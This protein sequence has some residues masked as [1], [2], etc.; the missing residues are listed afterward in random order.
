[1]IPSY[2]ADTTE[3]EVSELV[4]DMNSL[5]A[6]AE[7][8]LERLEVLPDTSL[9]DIYTSAQGADFTA[10]LLRAGVASEIQRRVG[11]AEAERQFGI[12]AMQTGRKPKTLKV[13]A[14]I[15][16]TF[17]RGRPRPQGTN[18]PRDFYS[19]ALADA[20]PLDAIAYA[21]ERKFA[22]SYTRDDFRMEIKRRN[23]KLTPD[24]ES[25]DPDAWYIPNIPIS[26]Q[27]K[28]AMMA[29]CKTYNARRRR[30]GN[31]K[32]VRPGEVITRALLVLAS[33]E[34][35]ADFVGTGEMPGTEAPSAPGSELDAYLNPAASWDDLTDEE[36]SS[37]RLTEEVGAA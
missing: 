27:A 9:V 30:Y 12:L 11:E 10:F 34:G 21:T 32:T 37:E 15:Y 33:M 4:H 17:F 18:L 31:T 28:S 23:G 20:D 3:Q 19:E 7:A 22:G 2:Y 6:K 24:Q 1:M 25:E 14:R 16:D 8:L 26:Q 5:E 35:L 29:L 13:D 36:E